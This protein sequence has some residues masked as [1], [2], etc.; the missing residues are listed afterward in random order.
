M[1]KLSV[2]K[3][4]EGYEA[5]DLTYKKLW[6]AFYEYYELGCPCESCFGATGPVWA[7]MGVTF[8][9]GVLDS[10][11]CNQCD[12]G[13]SQM[14]DSMLHGAHTHMRNQ[15]LT[16]GKVDPDKKEYCGCPCHD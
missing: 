14:I 12:P 13:C 16:L 5:T 4:L 2:K 3:W 10:C 9:Q 11:P 8:F 15:L 1:E 7:S 6:R